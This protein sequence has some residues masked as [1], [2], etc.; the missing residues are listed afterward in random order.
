[1]LARERRDGALQS[2]QLVLSA[3]NFLDAGP[4]G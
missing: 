4:H 1:L 2:E 3:E